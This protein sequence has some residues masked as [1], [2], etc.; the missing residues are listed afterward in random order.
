[1]PVTSQDTVADVL[2]Y[3]VAK[4]NIVCG[5]EGV[6]DGKLLLFER[7]WSVTQH[8][9]F[10]RKMELEEQPLETYILWKLNREVKGL[11]LT[12]H[13]PNERK[14]DK[15]SLEELE[16][17]VQ[18]LEEE[19]TAKIEQIRN[20]YQEAKLFITKRLNGVKITDLW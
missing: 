17:K 20:N 1:M 9:I 19:E 8:D 10:Y 14:Y 15:Y 16:Q 6:E 2:K 4:L 18:K 11:V 3:V 7:E 13:D 5:C 12:D